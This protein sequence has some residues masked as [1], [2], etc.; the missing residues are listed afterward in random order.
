M[1]KQK[2]ESFPQRL[3]LWR[4]KLRQYTLV[5]REYVYIIG[6]ISKYYMLRIDSEY[7]FMYSPRMTIYT[8]RFE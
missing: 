5:K 2:N 4:H 3:Y 6:L 7:E 8:S 1:N